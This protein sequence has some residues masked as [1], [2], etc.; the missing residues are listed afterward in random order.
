MSITFSLHK[1]N[2]KGESITVHNSSDP[3]LN[4]V[5]HWPFTIRQIISI[6]GAKTEWT[7]N[8]FLVRGKVYCIT[9]AAIS[10]LI[11]KTVKYIC[12]DKLGFVPEDVGIH[13]NRSACAMAM[14]LAN[15]PV[16]TIILIGRWS[17]DTFLLYT[18]KQVQEFTQGFVNK[19]LL[20]G[21]CF[22]ILNE[23]AGSED[24]WA[25]GNCCNFSSSAQNGDNTG[26]Q[27]MVPRFHLHH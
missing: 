7:V 2:I 11:K 10:R 9:G 8:W 4:P 16:Y 23:A 20:T 22:T 3:T 25:A 26:Q 18:Q 19:M 13:S 6:P 15:I 12:R 17:F 21:D 14:H 5:K 24:P 27:V 1:L